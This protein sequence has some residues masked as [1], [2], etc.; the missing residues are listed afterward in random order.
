MNPQ[1]NLTNDYFAT[2]T[3]QWIFSNGY[4]PMVTFDEYPINCVTLLQKT[5]TK[6]KTI[7]FLSPLRIFFVEE[8]FAI[9]IYFVSVAILRNVARQ[10]LYAIDVWMIVFDI[11]VQQFGNGHRRTNQHLQIQISQI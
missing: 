1:P 7:S 10:Q 2:A 11:F 4:F 3:F 6:F 5:H 8:D 9:T